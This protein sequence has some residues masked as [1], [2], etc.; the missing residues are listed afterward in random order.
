MGKQILAAESV[1]P[2]HP[3]PSTAG[4]TVAQW[5]IGPFVSVVDRTKDAIKNAMH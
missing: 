3:H 5:A 2:T 4:S 1:A